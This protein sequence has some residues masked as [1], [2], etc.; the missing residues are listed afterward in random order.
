[1]YTLTWIVFWPT[2]GQSNVPKIWP[3][4][5]WRKQW[6]GREE[7]FKYKIHVS[8][9][10]KTISANPLLWSII[11]G[12]NLSRCWLRV[13]RP[14][15]IMF[16]HTWIVF[17]PTQGRSNVPKRWPTN[18]WLKQS[19]GWQNLLKLNMHVSYRGKTLLAN[20]LLWSIITRPNLSPYWLKVER[21]NVNLYNL[22][23][24]I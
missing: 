11:T 5:N 7:Q 8:Y 23:F 6:I 15:Q 9:R 4:N 2:K 14:L 16:T 3:T 13:E 22:T 17:W 21:P 12:P 19:I 10:D 20:T 18:N 1:M 24:L